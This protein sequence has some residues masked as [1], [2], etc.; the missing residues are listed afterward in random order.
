MT[1]TYI[2]LFFLSFLHLVFSK[3]LMCSG[4]FTILLGSFLVHLVFSLTHSLY[5]RRS[6]GK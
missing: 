6:F 2:Y 4:I 1:H 5:M 3:R